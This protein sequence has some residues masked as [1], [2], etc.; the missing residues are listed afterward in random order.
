MKKDTDRYVVVSGQGDFYAKFV[1]GLMDD[2]DRS[3]II[4]IDSIQEAAMIM[5]AS[6]GGVL[7]VNM[8][9]GRRAAQS[10]PSWRT[11]EHALRTEYDVLQDLAYIKKYV[12]LHL[13]EDLNRQSLAKK[14]CLTPNYLSTIFK[15]HEHES[16]GRFIER[17]RI[18]RAAY[19]LATE[20]SRVQDIADRVGF[21]DA[22]Y[23]CKIFKKYYGVT[24]LKYRQNER[25]AVRRRGVLKFSEQDA[26]AA[27]RIADAAP[28]DFG[29]A[30][31]PHAMETAQCGAQ[32]AM[33]LNPLGESR[34]TSSSR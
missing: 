28:R 18:E 16:I 22:S 23:F 26:A 24:P 11:M 34:E 30:R 6:A 21:A 2:S 14:L 32:I 31:K 8:D 20:E 10:A 13:G 4:K 27:S 9:G 12:R 7:L 1:E 33:A 3:A 19:Y 29:S 25:Q 15:K 17:N 5:E